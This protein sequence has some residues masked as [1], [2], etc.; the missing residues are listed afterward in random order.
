MMKQFFHL[1]GSNLIVWITT[2]IC[3]GSCS[4]QTHYATR[5][6]LLASQPQAVLL[7]DS[8]MIWRPG[9][10]HTDLSEFGI[11]DTTQVCTRIVAIS[12]LSVRDQQL[13]YVLC[14]NT[15]YL[16]EDCGPVLSMTVFQR[17]PENQHFT[18][19][20]T[21]YF[22]QGGRFRSVPEFEFLLFADTI[23][24][25]ALIDGA[26]LQGYTVVGYFLFAALAGQFREVFRCTDLHV[27]NAGICE[28][29]NC[30]AYDTEISFS[31]TRHGGFNDI[32]L[33]TYG[34]QFSGG[35][36]RE[37]E[38]QESYVF[39]NDSLKYMRR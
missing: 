33:H 31:E 10:Q 15:P 5:E 14:T 8:A 11:D 24:A 28:E 39:D 2:C 1:T 6:I 20:Q 34:T 32:G 29:Q 22:F 18:T 16:C 12:E 21:S 37:I 38:S 7:S 26:T 17:T 27:D 36:L 30:F 13:T 3:A 4:A 9:P 23:Q 35:M 19:P 25:L